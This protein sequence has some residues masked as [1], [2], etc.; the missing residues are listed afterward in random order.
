MKVINLKTLMKGGTF[1]ISSVIN[2]SIPFLLLP[3]LTRIL[4]PEDY[5]TIAMFSIFLSLVSAFVGLSVHGAINVNYFKLTELEFSEYI[6]SCLILL[7][8]SA[9]IVFI[10]VSIVGPFVD[11]IMGI[12]YKWMLVAVGVSFFQ[13]LVNIQLTIWM[14][15]GSA[16]RYGSFQISQTVVN[17]VFSLFLILSMGMFW[18]GRLIGQSTAIIFFG[19]LAVYLLKQK[20]LIRKPTQFKHDIKDALKFGLP[21]IPHT[22]GGFA[23]Y[24][25]DRMVIANLL[26]VYA[27]G[28]YTVGAQLGQAMNLLSDS[29]NKVYSPWL[30]ENLSKEDL[31]KKTVVR[32]SYLAML[33]LLGSGLIW[34]LLATFA[35]PL[36]VGKKFDSAKD[37]ILLM[38]IAASFTGLYYIVTNYI[39]Y[40]KK[41]KFLSAL[42]F[43]SGVINIPLTYFMVK[44]YGIRGAAYSFLIVQVIT[45]LATWYL[46]AKVYRMPW[47]SFWRENENNGV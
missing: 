37:I 44:G 16:F 21:L 47:F 7:F 31:D 11:T 39:F 26:D 8:I 2:A 17:I 30:M 4:T 20:N 15:K 28:I 6:A 33:F 35:L 3:V 10:V 12:P 27:V 5:G 22:L 1:L 46:S 43:V 32:N 40:T 24:S 29:F 41:T 45:F 13:F 14:V 19:I 36:L 23:V 9:A 42:T 34:G 18:E 25:V 38:C